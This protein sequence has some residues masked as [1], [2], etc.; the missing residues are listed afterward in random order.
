MAYREEKNVLP[1]N[2]KR[3]KDADQGTEIEFLI[4][5][6]FLFHFM[7]KDKRCVVHFELINIY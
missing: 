7:K 2:S 1:T 4:D 6:N 3:I 5:N